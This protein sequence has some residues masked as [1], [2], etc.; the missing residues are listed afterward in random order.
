MVVVKKTYF[1]FGDFIMYCSL[2]VCTWLDG[3]EKKS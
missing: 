1:V 2:G 3:T